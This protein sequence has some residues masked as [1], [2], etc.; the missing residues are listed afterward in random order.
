MGGTQQGLLTASLLSLPVIRLFADKSLTRFSEEEVEVKD[1]I[2]T[3]RDDFVVNLRD[4]KRE[5][6]IINLQRSTPMKT[7]ELKIRVHWHLPSR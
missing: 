6:I 5:A 1:H 4:A 7:L 3:H 2:S